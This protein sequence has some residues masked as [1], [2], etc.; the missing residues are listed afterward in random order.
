MTVIVT[1]ATTA[2]GRALVE[3]L[4]RTREVVGARPVLL[5]R[6]RTLHDLL[7]GT[8]G[9]TCVVHDARDPEVTRHVLAA[10][11]HHPTIRRVVVRSSSDVYARTTIEPNLLDEDAP[12]DYERAAADLTAC[13]YLARLPLVVLRCAEVLAPGGQLWDYLQSRVCLRPLGYD[14]MLN[15]LSVEDQ[16]DALAAAIDSDVRGVLNI[17][18]A[19]TLPLS[20]MIASAGRRD[21]PLP[22]PLLAPAYQLRTRLVGFEFRYDLN[23]RRFHF[24]GILDG[25]RAQHQ[26]GYLARH[27]LKHEVCGCFSHWSGRSRHV[28]ASRAS[29]ISAS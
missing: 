10:C 15:V 23:M 16:L 4:Q 12:L 7:F 26:L 17:P 11:T 28:T 18:G 8:P 6:A 24:G 2:W 1:D 19:D 3:R 22:G 13:S 29:K 14:P 5:Q 21:I 25:T 20:R 27:L 9:V